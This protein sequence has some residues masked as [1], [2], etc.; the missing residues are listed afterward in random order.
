VEIAQVHLEG[1]RYPSTYPRWSVVILCE[2][3]RKRAAFSFEPEHLKGETL[4]TAWTYPFKSEIAVASRENRPY[5]I[6]FL[7]GSRP[8]PHARLAEQHRR[9][10][11][12]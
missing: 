9:Q 1:D 7:E 5:A 8:G 4:G 2:P 3:E 11:A 10:T 6:G 12:P